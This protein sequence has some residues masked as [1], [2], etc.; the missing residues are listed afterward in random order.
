MK[1]IEEFKQAASER[2]T[3]NKRTKKELEKERQVIE[4]NPPFFPSFPSLEDSSTDLVRAINERINSL[5]SNTKALTTAI[6]SNKVVLTQEQRSLASFGNEI[7]AIIKDISV[8]HIKEY[9]QYPFL[10]S[11]IYSDIFL[12]KNKKEANQ[13]IQ[14]LNAI[15][16][17][18]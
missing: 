6:N 18:E 10:R 9:F 8:D 2:I 15:D 14:E 1:E 17:T 16:C 5:D 4:D 12:V 13:K 7:K 3:E 11:G